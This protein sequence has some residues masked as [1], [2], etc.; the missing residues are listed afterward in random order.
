M[1]IFTQ[2]GR[3]EGNGR[4]SKDHM[5]FNFRENGKGDHSSPTEYKRGGGEGL[6]KI[7]RQSNAHNKMG[8]RGIRISPPPPPH[9]GTKFTLSS[10]NICLGFAPERHS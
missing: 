10:C 2:G 6:Q 7:D 3:W 1:D 9:H 8:G 5:V 4:I